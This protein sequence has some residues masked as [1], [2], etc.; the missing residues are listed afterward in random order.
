MFCAW[1]ARFAQL[2]DPQRAI[3]HGDAACERLERELACA[4]A[5]REQAFDAQTAQTVQVARVVG[6]LLAASAD[7]SRFIL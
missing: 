6:Q 1:D 4:I 5:L 3:L 2:L 7:L